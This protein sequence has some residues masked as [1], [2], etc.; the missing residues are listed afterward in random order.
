MTIVLLVMTRLNTADVLSMSDLD[1]F[2]PPISIRFTSLD[3]PPIG[4]VGGFLES[5]CDVAP[6][7]GGSTGTLVYDC[8]EK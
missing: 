6:H 1:A 8:S 3:S 2:E 7:E 5:G 4:D